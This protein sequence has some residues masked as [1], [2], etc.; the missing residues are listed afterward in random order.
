V[1][2]VYGRETAANLI[3]KVL[4]IGKIAG[5]IALSVTV[6]GI[7]WLLISIVPHEEW[8]K[9]GQLV[10]ALTILVPLG[11]LVVY[12]D[13]FLIRKFPKLGPSWRMGLIIFSGILACIPIV[14]I[15]V[16]LGVS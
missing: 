3:S 13:T 15:L 9:L 1:A 8:K 12:M 7:I 10:I 11:I 4:K 5:I 16:L 6:I 14:I 2:I